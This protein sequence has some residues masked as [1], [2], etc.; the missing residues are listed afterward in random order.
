VTCCGESH[1]RRKTPIRLYRGDFS[2]LVYAATRSVPVRRYD[3]GATSVTLCAT[4]R[5]DVTAAM[6]EFIRRNPEWVREQ[7]ADTEVTP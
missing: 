7:L 3:E 6:K 1:C 2:G 4:E 5:H